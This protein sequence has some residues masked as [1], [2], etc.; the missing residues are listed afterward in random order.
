[1][2]PLRGSVL[3]PN[4]S[5]RLRAGL[6]NCALRACTDALLSA[7]S[8]PN[9][10][11]CQISV[12]CPVLI[13]EVGFGLFGDCCHSGMLIKRIRP[14]TDRF[15][16]YSPRLLYFPQLCDDRHYDLPADGCTLRGFS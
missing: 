9:F 2:P 11:C 10:V 3:S 5:Q 6:M 12:C 7:C 13:L 15:A 16:F 4:A 14:A 1:M 8:L